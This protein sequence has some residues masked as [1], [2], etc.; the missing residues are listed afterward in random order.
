MKK[1][2]NRET[3]KEFVTNHLNIEDFGHLVIPED[4]RLNDEALSYIKRDF[5]KFIEGEI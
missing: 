5:K 3:I 4:S 2:I 1:D